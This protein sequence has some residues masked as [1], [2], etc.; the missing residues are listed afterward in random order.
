MAATIVTVAKIGASGTK[1]MIK[2]NDG[3]PVPSTILTNTIL[4]FKTWPQD[5]GHIFVWTN[6]EGEK[7]S[8]IVPSASIG[9]VVCAL[10]S[11]SGERFVINAP[12]QVSL[13]PEATV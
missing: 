8:M 1:I 2:I 10:P 4:D 9:W 7:M 3:H 11:G 12:C 13:S 6:D 5:G